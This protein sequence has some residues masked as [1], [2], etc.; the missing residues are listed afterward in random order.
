MQFIDHTG[1]VFSIPSYSRTP[2]GYEYNENEY[3]FW[4]GSEHSWKL[5]VDTYY[6]KPIRFLTET[7]PSS[8]EITV[9]SKKFGLLGSRTVEDK[10]NGKSYK[11]GIT[12]DE[13]V[14]SQA[15]HREDIVTI[16]DLT[17]DSKDSESWFLHTFYVMCC[18]DEAGTWETN[19]LIHADNEWCPIT[20]GAEI[21]DETE[22]LIING[23]NVGIRLP[24]DIIKAV[25]QSNTLSD[26]PDER[27]FAQKMKELLLNFM[28]IKG[29][30]GN[31]RSALNALKWFGWG[32]KISMHK[33]L[34]TDNDIIDQ[35]LRDK[36]EIVNDVIYAYKNFKND[37]LISLSVPITEEGEEVP[38]NFNAEFW[39]E[40][41]PEIIS[42]LDKDIVVHYDEGDIDFRR[43]YFDFTFAELGLKLCLLKYYYEKYFLPIHMHI[44]SISMTQQVWANDIKMMSQCWP[45]ITAQPVFITD[46]EIDVV[47]PNVTTQYFAY[48]SVIVDDNFNVFDYYTKE[49][50]DS[51]SEV[52][53][54]MHDTI[55]EIP[56]RFTSTREQQFYDVILSLYKDDEKIFS[57]NF[58]FTQ[59]KIYDGDKLIDIQN[60]YDKFIIHP[61]SLTTVSAYY[62]EAGKK[63]FDIINWLSSTYRIELYANGKNYSYEFNLKMPEMNLCMGRL[64][65][66]Y[67]ARF[68]QLMSVK[69]HE[70]TQT[71]STEITPEF[72][73]WMH[74]PGL[75][76]MN[77]IDIVRDITLFHDSLDKYLAKY[78]KSQVNIMS[79]KFL[80]VCHMYKVLKKTTVNNEVIWVEISG[81]PS[82]NIDE[83]LV[84]IDSENKG[85]FINYDKSMYAMMFGE[86]GN[87]SEDLNQAINRYKVK[88]DAFLMRDGNKVTYDANGNKVYNMKL[89]QM[90][91]GSYYLILITRDTVD[92]FTEKELAPPES[93]TLTSGNNEYRFEYERSDS[94]FLVNRYVLEDSEGV[95]HF[96]NDDLIAMYLKSNEHLPFKAGISTQW[97]VSPMSIGMSEDTKI[98]SP[99]E[100]AIIG[101][102]HKNFRYER[103]YYNVS[104]RFSLDDFMQHAMTKTAKFR[105][106]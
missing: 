11:D 27:L 78:Y 63:K 41:K 75:V 30:Q 2:I 105:I 31:Y 16:G 23:Q 43:S 79:R 17:M 69:T 26:V 6:M 57:R 33:L 55:V 8:I 10:M 102:G 34:K 60:E 101:V 24:K 51:C 14:I 56:I 88:Y 99:N 13:E 94:K 12:I 96:T 50:A 92:K 37:A 53:Y 95:N 70:N 40:N 35:Y 83:V 84:P 97:L 106:D 36:F 100:I 25:Y 68:R 29:E 28:S 62:E 74:M 82:Q 46:K 66:K 71:N 42:L 89:E 80:N 103:G 73:A 65:Y 5:S 32:D 59:A 49:Y 64:K 48:R 4:I 45:K 15:L 90:Q 86:N 93:F 39:G 18:S 67:D 44:N 87:E 21:V 77:N 104:C 76:T 54:Y 9:D 1:H 85:I 22:E 3:I 52:L 98:E 47:F 91:Y 81:K 7:M 38:F 19:I 20:V 61:K 72:L 58:M